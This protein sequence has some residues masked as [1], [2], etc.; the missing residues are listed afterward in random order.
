[1]FFFY[2]ENFMHSVAF[3][4]AVMMLPQTGYAAVDGLRRCLLPQD[5]NTTYPMTPNL[6]TA[7]I[8]VNRAARCGTSLDKQG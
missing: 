7:C 4:L 2:E 6:I 1:M 5:R 3:L 8:S